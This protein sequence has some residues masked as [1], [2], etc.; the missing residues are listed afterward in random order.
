MDIATQITASSE[1]TTAAGSF[2]KGSTWPRKAF[3]AD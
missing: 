1:L 2:A 3:E